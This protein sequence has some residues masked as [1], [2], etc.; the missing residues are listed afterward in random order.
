[1]DGSVR[2][3]RK[4]N[5]ISTSKFLIDLDL[6]TVVVVVTVR[7]CSRG[8]PLRTSNR[9]GGLADGDGGGA[10]AVLEMEMT[11]KRRRE[12]RE[13]RD[14]EKGGGL[15]SGLGE[16]ISFGSSVVHRPSTDGGGG[17]SRRFWA[18]EGLREEKRREGRV[19]RWSRRWSSVEGDEKSRRKREGGPIYYRY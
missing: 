5:D 8:S 11:D 19:R 10:A 3:R 13:G 9:S 12:R 7:R 15:F 4:R 18:V 16:E 17:S 1:M 14:G 2:I 6:T